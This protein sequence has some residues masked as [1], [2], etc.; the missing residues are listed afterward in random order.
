MDKWQNMQKEIG[1][2][3]L[4]ESNDKKKV[5]VIGNSHGDDLFRSFY[6]NKDLFSNYEFSILGTQIHCL[7]DNIKNNLQL[8]CLIPETF[9]KDKQLV[10]NKINQTNFKRAD[11]L[12]LSS[13]WDAKD[14]K[15]LKKIKSYVKDKKIIMVTS[16]LGFNYNSSSIHTALDK[17]LLNVNRTERKI[18]KEVKDEIEKIYFKLLDK[19]VLQLNSKLEHE[20]KNLNL[21]FLNKK[22]YACDIKKKK[23]DVLTPNGFKIYHDELHYTFEGA[24]Y[25]GKK[26]YDMD[27]LNAK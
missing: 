26:M 18:L 10:L 24:K 4:S 25:F 16:G 27:F 22:D 1:I 11:I 12:I 6:Y 3:I 13:R 7:H 8:K 23:C 17:F 15:A 21:I 20:V 5:L 19:K 9:N 14:I 2:P